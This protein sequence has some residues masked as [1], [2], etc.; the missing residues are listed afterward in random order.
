M[1]VA[2]G[3][4][5]RRA[6]G[7]S[8]EPCPGH[9]VHHTEVALARGGRVAKSASLNIVV[10]SGPRPLDTGCDEHIRVGG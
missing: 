1:A 8:A 7:L 10:F 6:R 9:C 2:S 4:A 3:C 5:V